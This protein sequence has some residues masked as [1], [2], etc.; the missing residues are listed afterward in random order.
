VF[1]PR[2]Q[3]RVSPCSGEPWQPGVLDT[4]DELA[5]QPG[6]VSFKLDP[7]DIVDG[8]MKPWRADDPEFL[9]PIFERIRS[10]GN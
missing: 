6:V 8:R 7:E 9:F 1:C 3:C 5:E 10:R 4:I 2:R